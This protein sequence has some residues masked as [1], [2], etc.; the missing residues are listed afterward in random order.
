MKSPLV[1][2]LL[3]QQSGVW[4]K[5]YVD[6]PD[7]RT[8]SGAFAALDVGLLKEMV[9]YE[10][11]SIPFYRASFERLELAFHEITYESLFALDLDFDESFIEFAEVPSV[12]NQIGKRPNLMVL[13]SL[14]KFHGV[15]RSAQ[16]LPARS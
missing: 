6:Q 14:T 9:D 7:V 15:S 3:S 2:L 16:G 12:A 10:R 13:R 11:E 5:P 1:S 8:E 4:H